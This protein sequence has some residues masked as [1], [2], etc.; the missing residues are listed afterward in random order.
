MVELTLCPNSLIRTHL[1]TFPRS[2]HHLMVRG[3]TEA[4]G[5]RLVYSENYHCAHNMSNCEYVNLQKSHDFDDQPVDPQANYIVMI[6]GFELAVESWYVTH[7]RDETF[8]AFRQRKQ[9][10]FD[11]FL[12]KWVAPDLPNRLLITYHDLVDNKLD[13]V[14]R[15]CLHMGSEPDERKLKQWERRERVKIVTIK[16]T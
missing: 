15:A 3:L 11:R 13:C 7:P 14:R 16:K 6:R 12:S 9:D 2:G 4:L 5:H 10:Y 1:V 8:E